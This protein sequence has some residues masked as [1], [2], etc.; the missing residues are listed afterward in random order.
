MAE[1]TGVAR[2]SAT[3]RNGVEGDAIFDICHASTD[4]AHYAH[5]YPFLHN[6]Q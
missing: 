2:S 4:R 6:T 3:P 5:F 1:A